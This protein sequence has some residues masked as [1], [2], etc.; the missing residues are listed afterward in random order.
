MTLTAPILMT[1]ENDAI[2]QGRSLNTVLLSV[3]IAIGGFLA[4]CVVN[5]LVNVGQI[6]ATQITRPELETKLADIRLEQ[7][8]LR[9][10]L[11]DLQMHM[12]RIDD[13]NAEKTGNNQ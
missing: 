6:Q 7:G 9:K 1:E 8:A 10:D 2:A 13:R 12:T 5:L 4:V 11:V 3:V